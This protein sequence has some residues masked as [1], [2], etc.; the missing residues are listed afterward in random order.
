MPLPET[1][2]NSLIDETGS[3][4]EADPDKVGF[5][6]SKLS[7]DNT[8]QFLPSSFTHSEGNDVY[9]ENE[10]CRVLKNDSETSKEQIVQDSINVVVPLKENLV[11]RIWEQNNFKIDE[12]P[13][14]GDPITTY[15]TSET[16]P[17]F[18]DNAMDFLISENPPSDHKPAEEKEA[19]VSVEKIHSSV[20]DF[21]SLLNIKD[22]EY[23]YSTN[24]GDN[25]AKTMKKLEDNENVTPDAMTADEQDRLLS[26]R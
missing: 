4:Y 14:E 3:Q 25:V 13:L 15:R 16:Q 5:T 21:N 22:F 6:P 11:E 9:K 18:E 19:I 2:G 17:R 23:L 7:S 8:Q 1:T 20:Q 26:S 10:N 24:D 12:D